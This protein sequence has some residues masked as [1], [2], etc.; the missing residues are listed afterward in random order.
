MRISSD[1]TLTP[2]GRPEKLAADRPLEE[3]SL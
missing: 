1:N 2:P 3:A